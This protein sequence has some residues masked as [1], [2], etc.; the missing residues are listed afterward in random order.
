MKNDNGNRYYCYNNN[1]KIITVTMIMIIAI[2]ITAMILML[3]TL[4]T[5]TTMMIKRKLKTITPRWVFLLSHSPPAPDMRAILGEP[6]G[7]STTHLYVFTTSLGDLPKP[8]QLVDR[9]TLRESLVSR[10][11]PLYHNIQCE[12]L[13]QLLRLP[14]LG[15]R[16]P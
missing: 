14:N 1:E 7:R 5:T 16:N 6:P 2:I 11:C 10:V 3:I 9:I 15:P 8:R 4:I 13:L 12:D